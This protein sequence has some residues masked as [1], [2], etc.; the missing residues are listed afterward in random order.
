MVQSSGQRFSN[1]CRRWRSGR[2]MS[3]RGAPGKMV[4]QRASTVVC[5]TSCLQWRSST[6]CVMR[7]PIA[8]RGEKTTTVTAHTVRL[9]ACPQT[10]SRNAVLIP[11]RSLRELRSISTATL[12]LLP[13]P[14][15][16]N[17]WIKNGGIPEAFTSS[18][19]VDFRKC[20]RR[21]CGT[22]S[23]ST[24]CECLIWER[25]PAEEPVP[26]TRAKRTSVPSNQRNLPHQSGQTPGPRQL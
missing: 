12:P 6:A 22:Q 21:A 20:E 25:S 23:P 2:C 5:E 24:S 16:H 10:R 19:F 8:R 3:R 26:P 1:G 4:T 17:T 15:S 11:L 9:A 13:N 7:E 18:E 14:Y